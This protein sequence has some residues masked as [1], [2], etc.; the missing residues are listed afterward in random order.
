MIDQFAFFASVRS[1]SNTK[2]NIKMIN[3]AAHKPQRA[4]IF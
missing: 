1:V 2:V 4:F 3:N